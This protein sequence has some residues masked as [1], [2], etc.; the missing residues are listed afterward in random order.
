MEGLLILFFVLILVFAVYFAVVGHRLIDLD[1]K[2]HTTNLL[3][4]V[5]ANKL[6]ATEEDVKQAHSF[7]ALEESRKKK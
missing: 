4:T 2:L 1:N 7:E 3:L 6:G 5:V